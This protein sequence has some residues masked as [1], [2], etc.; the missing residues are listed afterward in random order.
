MKAEVFETLN[1]VLADHSAC[2][3]VTN[4]ETGEQ[5]IVV[6]I[7]K[8]GDLVLTDDQTAQVNRMLAGDV[9]G[10]I[11]DTALFVR[12]YGPAPRM[13]I[14]GA[15]HIAQALAPMARITG[16]DVTVID[17]REAFVK[18]GRLDDVA[19]ITDWPDEGMA[20]LNPDGR[21]AVVTLTHDP[22]LDDPALAAALRS[23]AFYIGSL[24]S[25][26]THAKRL[27]RLKDE[28]FSDQELA[29]IHGP[30][31]LDIK[32]K[33]P[34]EIAIAILGEVVEARRTSPV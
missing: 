3:A 16:F 27:Q 24:G 17:P 29:R 12:V 4:T 23:P 10:P 5:A 30:I 20:K 33:T 13:I 7:D 18:A 8:T 14:V 31:G 34:A 11:G 6:G 15:V 21:T 1:H 2:A 22:K 28:G 26:R 19:A 32:A 9:S 25:T